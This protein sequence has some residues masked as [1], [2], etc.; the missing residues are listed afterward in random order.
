MSNPLTDMKKITETLPMKGGPGLAIFSSSKQTLW[1]LDMSL[2][3]TPHAE[4]YLK[5]WFMSVQRA[6]ALWTEK[7]QKP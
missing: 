2:C 5:A 1:P 7:I 6:M 3:F 4:G